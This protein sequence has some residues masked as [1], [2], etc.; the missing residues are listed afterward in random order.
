MFSFFKYCSDN[1]LVFT[2][3]SNFLLEMIFARIDLQID[4][5]LVSQ[6][7]S[8]KNATGASDSINGDY[9]KFIVQTSA[10][11]Y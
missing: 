11:K 6:G 2:N 8:L 1:W 4:F 5:D 10:Y 7:K 9:N 3:A